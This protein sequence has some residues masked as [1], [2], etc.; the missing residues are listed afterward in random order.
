MSRL[1]P[2]KNRHVDLPDCRRKVSWITFRLMPLLPS[3]KARLMLPH[4][5]GMGQYGLVFDPNDL[6]VNED[7]AVTHRFLDLN[8]PLRRMPDI[9][10]RIVLAH[11]QG[12][13]QKGF[14]ERTKRLALRFVSVPP[15]PVLVLTIGEALRGVV[16]GI[17]G[18]QIRRIGSAELCSLPVHQG[19]DIGSARAVAAHQSMLPNLPD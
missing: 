5:E 16:L 14:I 8:L 18:D 3:E 1:H 19:R 11:S 12:L 4:I 9:D 7:S 13:S 10:S 15:L 6:L 2:R 17:V